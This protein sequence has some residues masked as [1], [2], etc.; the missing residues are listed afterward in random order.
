MELGNMMSIYLFL[1]VIVSVA[2]VDLDPKCE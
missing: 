2:A 1:A